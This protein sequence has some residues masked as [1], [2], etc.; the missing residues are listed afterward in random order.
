MNEVRI[1]SESNPQDLQARVNSCLKTY[2]TYQL[3]IEYGVAAVSNGTGAQFVYSA[4]V[5][6]SL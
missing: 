6:I 3:R 2:K 1:F 4:L 5:H